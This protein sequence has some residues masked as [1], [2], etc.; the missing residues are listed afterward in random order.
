MDVIPFLSQSML[1]I[2][3]D[4]VGFTKNRTVEDQVFIVSKLESIILDTVKSFSIDE[5]KVLYAPTGDGVCISI[6]EWSE[7]D[8]HMKI[9]LKIF[10][11]LEKHNTRCVETSKKISIRAGIDSNFDAVRPDI[12]RKDN[13]IGSGINRAARIMSLA[14]PDQLMISSSV[15][16]TLKDREV[17]RDLF[18]KKEGVVK[19]N[20]KIDTYQYVGK[21]PGLDNEEF[22]VDL[23][24]LNEPIALYLISCSI[25][26]NKFFDKVPKNKGDILIFKFKVKLYLK[27]RTVEIKDAYDDY[28]N[29]KEIEYSERKLLS[30]MMLNQNDVQGVMFNEYVIGMINGFTNT[31]KNYFQGIFCVELKP[32]VKNEIL[33][34]YGDFIEKLNNQIDNELIQ[35][36]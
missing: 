31:I 26:R 6:L 28:I 20:T 2:F 5:S 14:R 16:D 27:L 10:E 36:V 21:H 7:Y 12:N 11:E 15:F 17:Y 33:S 19:H 1:H 3:I 35:D 9:C 18:V 23:K 34:V 30:S 25:N 4:I 24:T 8:I 29:N 13:V 22:I 32:E